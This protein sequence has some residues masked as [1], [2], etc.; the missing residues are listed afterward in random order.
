MFRN[1]KR[2]LAVFILT[3]ISFSALIPTESFAQRESIKDINGNAVE[4]FKEYIMVPD[5]DTNRGL[6]F[7][8]YN[9]WD[10]VLPQNYSEANTFGGSAIIFGTQQHPVLGIDPGTTVKYGDEIYI[11]ML[12]SNHQN[13]RY[14]S[15]SNG[16]LRDNVWLDTKSNATK[17]TVI[18]GYNRDGAVGFMESGVELDVN[19]WTR[20]SFWNEIKQNYRTIKQPKILFLDN[21]RD[22]FFGSRRITDKHWLKSGVAGVNPIGNNVMNKSSFILIPKE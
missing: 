8:S 16:Y 20:R 11:K 22:K 4:Y 18:P 14:F 13:Y 1:I 9:N 3:I 21:A 12:N 19:I 17:Y 2:N 10:Y 6:T 7:E 5:F 15:S